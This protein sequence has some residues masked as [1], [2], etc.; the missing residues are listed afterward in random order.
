MKRRS[1]ETKLV[2]RMATLAHSEVGLQCVNTAMSMHLAWFGGEVGIA[3]PFPDV[4]T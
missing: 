4:P 2:G 3:R 1:D